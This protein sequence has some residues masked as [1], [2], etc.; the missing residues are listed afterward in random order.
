ME[1]TKTTEELLRENK[2]WRYE[3][4]D[5]NGTR[6]FVDYTC[7]RCG[8][9]GGWVG[10]PGYTCYECGGC[11][12]SA[13]GSK[14]KVYTPEH[15]AKLAAQREAR[16]QKAQAEREAKLIAERGDNLVKAGFGKENDGYVIYR[17][18]GNTFSI[19]DELKAAG[20]KYKPC[21]GWYA[22]AALDGYECQRLTEKQVLDEVPAIQWKDIN[23]VKPLWTETTRAAEESTSEWQGDIGSRLTL[24]L[25][26]DRVF[27][28][29]FYRNMGYYG[30]EVSYM[31]LMSDA[32]GN[33]YKWST[34]KEYEEDST[35]TFKATVKE[36]SEYKGIKQTV[37]T[38][39]TL[40]K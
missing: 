7:S 4:T 37:L 25:H 39:C 5:R 31:Y 14:I 12:V 17:V 38:R 2:K 32:A 34:S 13:R 40:V 23:D 26:I 18:V 35:V 9:S 24:T 19:K 30:S 36:H 29:T 16:A 1:S 20:C 6:Y 10:W 21:V 11:G 27:Q 15:A 8:G 22:P 3:R 28:H 33:Q